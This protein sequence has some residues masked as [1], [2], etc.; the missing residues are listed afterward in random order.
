MSSLS[1]ETL[2]QNLPQAEERH[3]FSLPECQECGLP[4][5]WSPLP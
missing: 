3:H 5:Q 1:L 2:M 4:M